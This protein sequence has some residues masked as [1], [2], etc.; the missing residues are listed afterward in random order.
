VSTYWTILTIH[1]KVVLDHSELTDSRLLG[2]TTD[3]TFSYYSI[4]HEQQPTL[5]ASGTEWPAFRTHLLCMA[6]V[7]QLA[8]ETL[9]SSE[10]VNGH[11]MRCEAHERD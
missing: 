5:E 8:V 2:I 4:T 7:I 9:N 10:G 6:N 3:N 11:I 1:L